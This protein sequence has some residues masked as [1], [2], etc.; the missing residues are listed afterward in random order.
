MCAVWREWNTGDGAWMLADGDWVMLWFWD[1]LELERRSG[2][3]GRLFW[4]DSRGMEERDGG[5]GS[6]IRWIEENDW[7]F[8][9]LTRMNCDPRE[10]GERSGSFLQCFVACMSVVELRRAFLRSEGRMYETGLN[11]VVGKQ[12]E[13]HVCGAWFDRYGCKHGLKSYKSQSKLSHVDINVG[14]RN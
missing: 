9:V 6:M 11:W 2:T 4:F 1:V 14:S 5:E 10:W 7:S 3:E 8:K 13:V 12:Y